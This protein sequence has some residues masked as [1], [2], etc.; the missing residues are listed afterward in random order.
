M[1]RML[2]LARIAR[3]HSENQK[4]QP[5]CRGDKSSQ[6]RHVAAE[7]AR[8]PEHN[9]QPAKCDCRVCHGLLYWTLSESVS[10]NNPAS[11]VPSGAID[12]S[13]MNL[14]S[15]T[16]PR[17]VTLTRDPSANPNWMPLSLASSTTMWWRFTNR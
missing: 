9:H 17:P 5:E 15:S 11:G 4:Q 7:V 2:P 12:R 6:A 1:H 3:N 14:N 13:A 8:N 10:F 16:A